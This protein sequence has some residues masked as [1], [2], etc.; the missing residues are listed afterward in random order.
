MSRLPPKASFLWTGFEGG[1]SCIAVVRRNGRSCVA[2]GTK[3]GRVELYDEETRLLDSILYE[4]PQERGIIWIG[5]FNGNIVIHVRTFALLCFTESADGFEIL[6]TT[7]HYGHCAASLF[8]SL[9]AIPDLEDK[10]S[11]V[12]VMKENEAEAK[13]IPLQNQDWMLM[14]LSIAEES[15][16]LFIGWDSGCVEQRSIDT[17]DKRASFKL[18]NEPIFAICSTSSSLFAAT[19]TS[20]IH[21]LRIVAEV[22]VDEK[23]T[24]DYN[25]SATGCSCLR[26]TPSEK[27]IFASFWDGSLRAYSTK[28]RSL[29]LALQVCQGSPIQSLCVATNQ[30]F[31]TGDDLG[32]VFFWNV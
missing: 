22:L 15:N 4:D 5:T 27:T 18:T 23:E 30:K 31:Y 16:S 10:T 3:K 17:G 9:L 2:I 28:K 1:V 12:H 6:L 13:R 21:V 14:C 24:I 32:Q 25:L 19:S 20:P 8:G 7:Q 11:V 29:L 26:L